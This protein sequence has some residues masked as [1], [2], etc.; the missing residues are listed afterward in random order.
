[1]FAKSSTF[2]IPGA[3]N[4]ETELAFASRTAAAH[5]QEVFAELNAIAEE[6]EQCRANA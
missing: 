3:R 4:N 2:Q 5:D 1:M 6:I